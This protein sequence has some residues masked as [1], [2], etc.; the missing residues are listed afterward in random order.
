LLD[1]GLDL[2][3]IGAEV[4]IRDVPF[5]RAHRIDL[6]GVSGL[7]QATG[8]W[9]GTACSLL[10][11]VDAMVLNSFPDKFRIALIADRFNSAARRRV[12]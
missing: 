7:E 12:S 9:R 10:S 11:G 6:A 2:G 8:V 1:P 3:G 4:A 5:V